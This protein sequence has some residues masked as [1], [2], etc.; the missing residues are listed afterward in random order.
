MKRPEE[1]G[2]EIK[3]RIG[4]SFKKFDGFIQE[5]LFP[6]GFNPKTGCVKVSF[7]RGFLVNFFI[8]DQWSAGMADRLAGMYID[9]LM[10]DAV[11]NGWQFGWQGETV[12]IS[13]QICKP[14]VEEE[15][16]A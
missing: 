3:G 11:D 15:K 6:N 2:E 8:K 16:K 13:A 5:T 1:I 9:Q 12:T 10:F 4:K 14:C 7:T